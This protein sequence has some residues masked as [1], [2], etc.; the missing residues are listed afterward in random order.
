MSEVVLKVLFIVGTCFLVAGILGYMSY[1]AYKGRWTWFLTNRP[2]LVPVGRYWGLL[3]CAMWASCA[4]WLAFSG[5]YV[6]WANGRHGNM[7]PVESFLI[8]CSFIMVIG[9]AGWLF[10]WW[11]PLRWR[12]RW[13]VDHDRLNGRVPPS[14]SQSRH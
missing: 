14:P 11:L 1:R 8:T 9:G 6:V 4:V 10:S 5:S 13:L 3:T 2:F 7:S 12:P